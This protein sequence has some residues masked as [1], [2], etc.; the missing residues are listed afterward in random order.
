[1]HPNFLYFEN[2]IDFSSILGLFGAGC[3][4][5]ASG[6]DAHWEWCSRRW[7]I[8]YPG[9]TFADGVKGAALH[10]VYWVTHFSKAMQIMHEKYDLNNEITQVKPLM[11][12]FSWRKQNHLYTETITIPWFPAKILLLHM[13]FLPYSFC[14]NFCSPKSEYEEGVELFHLAPASFQPLCSLMETAASRVIPVHHSLQTNPGQ[15]GG[16]LLG[17]KQGKLYKTTAD[18]H[19]HKSQKSRSRS[20]KQFQ[21]RFVSY[22]QKANFLLPPSKWCLSS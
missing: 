5:W 12:R 18:S 15:T 13:D 9:N 22:L 1:M 7:I 3:R 10:Q 21:F 11:S 6:D 4:R 16:C 19:L 8:C 14:Q 20:Q 17:I 2:L